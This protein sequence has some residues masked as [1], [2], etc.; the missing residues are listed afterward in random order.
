LDFSTERHLPPP[1]SPTISAIEPVFLWMVK[2][3]R[4]G[5]E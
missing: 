4:I 3:V 2:V 5:S 1:F